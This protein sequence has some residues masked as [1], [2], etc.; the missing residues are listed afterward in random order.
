MA[1][2]SIIPFKR[3]LRIFPPTQAMPRVAKRSTATVRKAS[4]V[5]RPE[6]TYGLFAALELVNDRFNNVVRDSDLGLTERQFTELLHRTFP[7]LYASPP[8]PPKST[9][10]CIG[11]PDRVAIYAARAAA[12]KSLF[13]PADVKA[14]LIGHRSPMLGGFVNQTCFKV[15]GWAEPKYNGPPEDPDA[16]CPDCGMD[17]PPSLEPGF[18]HCGI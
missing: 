17:L 8:A 2:R 10:T 16:P 9:D 7:E 18:C 4:A 13:H 6:R 15:T 12:G 3:P 14:D 1:I 11:T 5:R